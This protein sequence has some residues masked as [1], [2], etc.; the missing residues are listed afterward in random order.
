MFNHFVQEVFTTTGIFEHCGSGI[1][2]KSQLSDCDLLTMFFARKRAVP[3]PETGS[4]HERRLAGRAMERAE[5]VEVMT[6]GQGIP[7]VRYR[8]T[9]VQGQRKAIGGLRVLALSC[10]LDQ[11]RQVDQF[12]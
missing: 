3:R 10:F 5:V 4:L 2:I 12:L 6:D 11:F 7:H 1:T 8:V 9:H